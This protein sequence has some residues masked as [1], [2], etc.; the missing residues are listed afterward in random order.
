M[1]PG[2]PAAVKLKGMNVRIKLGVLILT[3]MAVAA[4]DP[5][6]GSTTSPSSGSAKEWV[7]PNLVGS[8]LQDAQNAMQKLTGDPVFLTS[9]HDATG[10]S[11]QQVA[12]RN[13]KVCGQNVAAGSSITIKSVID[14]AAVKNEEKCP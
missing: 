13:W 10:K 11:R 3:T 6:P 4:C 8:N 5:Q 14:F 1:M 7:M 12:D 2:R 9:S